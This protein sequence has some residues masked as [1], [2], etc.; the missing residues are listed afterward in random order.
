MMGGR[1]FLKNKYFMGPITVFDKSAIQSLSID[2]SV[3]FDQ[4]LTG[5]ITPLFYVETLADLE[6]L[7]RE[8]QTPEGV[9]GSIAAR[10]PLEAMPNVHHHTIVLAELAGNEQELRGVPIIA[11]GQPKRTPSGKTAMLFEEFPE[12]AALNRWRDGEFLEVER[13]I[14]KEWRRQLKDLD[15]DSQIAKLVNILP[16]G[17]EFNTLEALKGYIDEFCSA[18][19]QPVLDLMMDILD[20]PLPGRSKVIERWSR[21]GKPAIDVFAPYSIHVFKVDLLF[22]LGIHRGFIS[23]VRK[24][25]KADMAYLYYLPFCMA[26]TSGDNLHARTVPLFLKKRQVFLPATELKAALKELNEHYKKLP[27]E[28][29]E[30]GVMQFCGYPP[31]SL[32]NL[33]TQLWDQQMRR[34]W[35]AI[36]E[37]Q[38]R[39]LLD[40][41][42]KPKPKESVKEIMD[43]IEEAVPLT[44]AEARLTADEADQ[45]YLKRVVPARRGSWRTVSQAVVDAGK[46]KRQAEE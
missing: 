38:E 2:E 8:G 12:A 35:R 45:V 6:K 15:A 36:A 43:N 41:D 31:S 37:D 4:F 34:D 33:V 25:N 26:F 17:K 18:S 21:L 16:Y 42:Y 3:W 7:V 1:G 29:K 46:K 20:V 10:T 13:G 9:V 19:S 40:P 39:R 27:E 44:G 14:A 11:G 28:I 23:D 32:D 30:L 22:Y 5:N 24:S